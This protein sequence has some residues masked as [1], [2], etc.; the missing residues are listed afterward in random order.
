MFEL[1]KGKK[2]F[3]HGNRIELLENGETFFPQLIRR[4]NRAE[5]EIFIETFILSEDRVG[6]ALQKALVAAAKRG[7][8]ISVTADSY[9]TFFLDA[10]YIK[11]LT[12]AGVVF[13][14]FDPQPSWLKSRPNLFR[15]LHR[16]LA[17]IDGRYAFI[18]GI[19]LS[20]EHMTEHGP[21]AKQDYAVE[22]EGPVVPIIRD[23]CKAYVPDANDKHLGELLPQMRQTAKVGDA[24][25]AF[26]ARDNRRFRNDIEKA[27]LLG[28]RKARKRIYIAN[29]YFF[30]SFRILR[31]LRNAAKRG[32]DVTV[33]LQG[34]PDIPLAL[35]AA[36][37]LYDKLTGDGI[38][39]YEYL[40]RPLHAKIALIDDDWATI[41]SSNL[42]PLSLA[43]NLEA[44][45]V[46]LDPTFNQQLFA[47]MIKLRQASRLI[48]NRWLSRRSRVHLIKNFISYHIMRHWPSVA[49]WFPTHTPVI[50]EIKSREDMEDKS[51]STSEVDSQHP[52]AANMRKIVEK[53][54]YTNLS[55]V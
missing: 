45:V 53:R 25:I 40:E 19:N 54:D 5:K 11:T 23:L 46:V 18:G 43:L 13:Q 27:Y 17:V 42:D 32:V 41:G 35:R 9:G 1:Y 31:A 39:V 52:E 7:V 3:T 38:K 44:N 55:E 47:E 6:N 29:A 20:H 50:R 12:E 16:K 15:R 21:T 48:E 22:V 33:I 49:S 10:D 28:I 51:L 24:S 37:C 14:I 26:V 34:E 2:R 8:W 30:P 36:R 4:I